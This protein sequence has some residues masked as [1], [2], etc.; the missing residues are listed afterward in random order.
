MSDKWK[1]TEIMARCFA[2]EFHAKFLSRAEEKGRSLTPW[3]DF[4]FE[5][6]Y[7][8]LIEEVEELFQADLNDVTPEDIMDECKDVASFAWF[9]Y[10]QAKAKRDKI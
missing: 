4:V 7:E 6:L 8:R 2:D 9:I 10:E 1:E 3:S 5:E